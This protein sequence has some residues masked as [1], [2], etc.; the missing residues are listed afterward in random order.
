[1]KFNTAVH[2]SRRKARAAHFSAD[3]ESRRKIMSAPLSKELRAKY[4]VRSLPIRK[5]DEVQVVRGTYKARDGKVT[6]VYRKK[7]SAC[8]WVVCCWRGGACGGVAVGGGAC[9]RLG[10]EGVR[11][12]SNARPSFCAPRECHPLARTLL[13]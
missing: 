1:M 5:E 10:G 2:S 12:L 4:R 6:Q 11:R 7:V 3:S 9:A 13:L 8:S